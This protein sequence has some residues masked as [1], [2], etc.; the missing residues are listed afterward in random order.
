MAQQS[1]IFKTP[2]RIS[3]E[4]EYS[5]K[6]AYTLSFVG[7]IVNAILLY[8]FYVTWKNLKEILSELPW[9][10]CQLVGMIHV[11]FA[12]TS[13]VSAFFLSVERYQQIVHSK[14]LSKNQII[15]TMG[16]IWFFFPFMS[17]IPIF[18]KA[19]Y[20]V[21]PCETW[22][23]PPFTGKSSN[24]L[25]FMVL[26]HMLLWSALIGIP[27]CYWKIYK[28]ALKH[29]FKWGLQKGA[30]TAVLGPS[31]SDD[32][33]DIPDGFSTTE[34]KSQRQTVKNSSDERNALRS[35][36]KLTQ[37]LGV[38]VLQFYV[39]WFG[40]ALCFIVETVHKTHISFLA[41]TILGFV[42]L[43]SWITNPLIILTMDNQLRLRKPTEN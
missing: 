9:E 34:I 29:G 30:V 13:G 15:T 23:L 10:I 33:G 1:E 4:N 28:F 43:L 19:Y 5:A 3:P 6:S 31:V 11:T 16:F 21:R 20:R 17:L 35:Q 38:L 22:C 18:T 40:L 37:K 2:W 36:L 27:F 25:P 24:E 12:A 14:T 39:G 42:T 26:A 32:T 8:K 7:I 41:D